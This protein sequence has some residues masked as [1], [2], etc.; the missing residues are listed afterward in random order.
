[1]FVSFGSLLDSWEFTICGFLATGNRH[2]SR[3]HHSDTPSNLDDS[4]FRIGYLMMGTL[5]LI[6]RGIAKKEGFDVNTTKGRYR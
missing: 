6:R 5:S 3:I 4:R 1:M 2:S